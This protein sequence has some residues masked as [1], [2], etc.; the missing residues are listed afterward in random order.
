[1]TITTIVAIYFL[2]W[3]VTL[4]CCAAFWHSVRRGVFL[5]CL[6]LRHHSVW[7]ANEDFRAAKSWVNKAIVQRGKAISL[8]QR[9]ICRLLVASC[10]STISTFNSFL[11]RAL[12]CDALTERK[13]LHR[14]IIFLRCGILSEW[15]ILLWETISLDETTPITILSIAFAWREQFVRQETEY[16]RFWWTN[17]SIVLLVALLG[18]AQS[19]SSAL[20]S[21]AFYCIT[22]FFIAWQNCDLRYT[23]TLEIMI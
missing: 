11:L 12:F 10:R 1:M 17:V 22:K 7:L 20:N 3:R 6:C 15:I 14:G 9:S 13:F 18:V 5:R 16:S 8:S 2:I 4:F 23:A 19:I 21:C